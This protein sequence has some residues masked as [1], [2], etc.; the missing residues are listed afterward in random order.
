MI[1]S[2]DMDDFTGMYCTGEVYPLMHAI[3]HQLTAPL[4]P[5]PRKYM[6]KPPVRPS[7]T[8]VHPSS[9]PVRPIPTQVH[10]NSTPVRPSS[11][12]V[13]PIITPVRTN[14]T[15]VR[16][17]PTPVRPF[18]TPVRP[19]PT[20]VR[21]IPDPT[22]QTTTQTPTPPITEISTIDWIES[23]SLLYLDYLFPNESMTFT[24]TATTEGGVNTSTDLNTH[25]KPHRTLPPA[26]TTPSIP[27]SSLSTTVPTTRTEATTNTI[28]TTAFA[29]YTPSRTQP[30]RTQPSRTQQPLV[31]KQIQPQKTRNNII[32]QQQN[33]NSRRMVTVNRATNST[34]GLQRDLFAQ[35]TPNNRRPTTGKSTNKKAGRTHKKETKLRN[36]LK[37]TGAVP[38]H[39]LI[40]SILMLLE[41]ERRGSNQPAR[42]TSINTGNWNR[43]NANTN[44]RQKS[45]KNTKSIRNTIMQA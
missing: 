4:P 34:V 27:T 25:I 2:L 19:I 12:P 41:S 32:G 44:S 15:P 24:T 31:T 45:I 35:P 20:L 37:E 39:R 21:L 5:N 17:I 38:S 40:N 8:P 28:K 30:S 42:L 36:I 33:W 23:S 10:P 22:T 11:A 3:H 13:H 14:S 9:A 43:V 7:P 16:L 18:P 29:A 26:T 6:N 1:T